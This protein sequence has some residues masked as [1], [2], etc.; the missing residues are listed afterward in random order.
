M[1]FLSSGKIV[2]DYRIL[3]RYFE[4][5]DEMNVDKSSALPSSEDF[6]FIRRFLREGKKNLLELL[7]ALSLKFIPKID[8][9]AAIRTYRE[10]LGIE[11]QPNTAVLHIAKDLAGWTLEMAENLGII[12]IDVSMLPS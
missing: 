1:L 6:E 5:L 3:R 4:I 10:V 8:M 11:I 2:K 9:N 12:K 7:E